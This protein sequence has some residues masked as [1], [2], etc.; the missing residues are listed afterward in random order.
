MLEYQDFFQSD[1]VLTSQIASDRNTPVTEHNAF[2]APSKVLGNYAF[3]AT[4]LNMPILCSFYKILISSSSNI[5][6]YDS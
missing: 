3:T 1:S 5:P 6:I 2:G 4:R